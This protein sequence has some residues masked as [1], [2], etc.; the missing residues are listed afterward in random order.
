MELSAVN[1]LSLFRL[2][3][4]TEEVVGQAESSEVV[5]LLSQ[6]ALDVLAKKKR[7]ARSFLSQFVVL[8]VIAMSD[9]YLLVFR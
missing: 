1:L 2:F 9:L 3:R 6:P 7:A 8:F 4:R 5:E